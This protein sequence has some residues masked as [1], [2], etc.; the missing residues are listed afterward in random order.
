MTRLIRSPEKI[1]HFKKVIFISTLKY[2]FYTI[3][4]QFLKRN[5]QPT[6]KTTHI[7]EKSFLLRHLVDEFRHKYIYFLQFL[8]KK[9]VALRGRRRFFGKNCILLGKAIFSREK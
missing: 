8:K 2:G 3:K 6:L 5:T 9:C 4:I 1:E 7:L